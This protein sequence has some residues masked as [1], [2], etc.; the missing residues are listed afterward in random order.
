MAFG[1]T[2]GREQVLRHTA[3]LQLSVFGAETASV[4][5]E[6]RSV[7]GDSEDGNSEWARFFR[8]TFRVGAPCGR[9]LPAPDPDWKT[10]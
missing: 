3:C 10:W 9:L 1:H 4:P 5:A 6:T 2:L 8:M 7:N